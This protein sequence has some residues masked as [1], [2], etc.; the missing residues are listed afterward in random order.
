[1]AGR[2][3]I[4]LQGE[5]VEP[6]PGPAGPAGGTGPQGPA[7]ATGGTGAT[8]PAGPQGPPGRDAS[9]RWTTRAGRV[10]VTRTVRFVAASRASVRVRLV[11]GS[12]VV[13]SARRSVRRGRVAMD[14]RARSRIRPGR[15]TLLLTFV[16]VD[17]R[18]RTPSQRVMMR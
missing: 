6:V 13:A 11:R 16:D 7:G 2:S 10:R 4:T 17:G 15:H 9:V 12:A 18:A 5:G 8:G 14:M 1:V 3:R